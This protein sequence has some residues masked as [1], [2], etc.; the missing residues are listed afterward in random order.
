MTRVYPGRGWSGIAGSLAVA[1]LVAAGGVAWADGDDCT[2]GRHHHGQDDGHSRKRHRDGG[3]GD[4]DGGHQG[5]EQEGK[6]RHGNGGHGGRRHHGDGGNHDGGDGGGVGGRNGGSC[7]TAL[8]CNDGDP[9]TDDSCD[10]EAGCRHVAIENCT[11][12]QTAADCSD[13]D[14]HT[15]D[16]C[17][18]DGVCEHHPRTG[19]ASNADCDDRNSCTTDSCMA[20]VCVN[21]DAPGCPACDAASACVDPRCRTA[22]VC[23]G[24]REICGDGVDNDGN[25]LID[26]DDPACCPQTTGLAIRHMLFKPAPRNPRGR[27]LDL[28]SRFAVALPAGFDPKTQDTSLQMSD[29]A[30][31]LFERTITSPNWAAP[32]ARLFRFAD[33]VGTVGGGLYMARFK[34]KRDGRV[35]FRAVGRQM[36]LRATDGREVRVTV[37]VGNLCAQTITNLRA[38]RT[39]RVLNHQ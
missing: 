24:P 14:W 28:R 36:G 21:T 7:S 29:G 19:C 37:R 13:G 1:A 17:T 15:V 10:P 2:A 12:C 8:D 32:R 25:G 9:C 18:A 22:P 33:Q 31:M 20:G 30:G 23:A 26:F 3:D 11:R 35:V 5:G 27:N 4:D 16:V 39:R 38:K 6:G 34:V